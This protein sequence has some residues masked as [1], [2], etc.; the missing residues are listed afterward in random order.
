[1]RDRGIR[2][3]AQPASMKRSHRI[4]VP[5]LSFKLDRSSAASSIRNCK[6]EKLAIGVGTSLASSWSAV[7][8]VMQRFDSLILWS[9]KVV[10]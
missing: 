5:P 9:S 8:I 3:V 2:D 7:R 1:M 6:P 10:I 4:R